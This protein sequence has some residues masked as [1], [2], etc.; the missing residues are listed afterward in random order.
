MASIFNASY[1]DSI[2]RIES[3]PENRVEKKDVPAGEK[4]FTDLLTAMESRR[5]Q[6]VD[7]SGRGALGYQPLET[8]PSPN[9]LFPN[10][11]LSEGGLSNLSTEE[12]KNLLTS[13]FRALNPVKQ[14]LEAYSISK[15]ELTLDR[16]SNVSNQ[17]VAKL[18]PPKVESVIEG[19]PPAPPKIFSVKKTQEAPPKPL[20]PP[21]NTA[22]V[23]EDELEKIIGAAGRHHGIDPSLSVAVAK[24]E[25]SLKINAV[26]RDGHHS[27]GVFQLLDKTGKAMMQRLKHE[28]E[29]NPFDPKLNAHLGVGYLRRL[30]DLFSK[31]SNLGFNLRTEPVKSVADL[32]KVS[33]A[34]FNAGEGNVARAQRLAREAGKDPSSYDAIAPHLPASTRTYVD[35][36]LALK[37]ISD[38]SDDE[39]NLA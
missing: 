16:S 26:S 37:S 6:E 19:R 7:T 11:L 33:V 15:S 17:E 24:A 23:R 21:V 34:A 32:E 27:K 38:I 1:L 2:R 22:R 3:N 30:H 35:R 9:S 12:S 8:P 14:G 10:A 13:E 36:V 39:T 28:G 25:S 29:Y 18:V 5:T 31:S 20:L 4:R